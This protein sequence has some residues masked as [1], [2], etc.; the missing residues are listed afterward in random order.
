MY[1]KKKQSLFVCGKEP[2]A[3]TKLF[4]KGSAS[5]IF[6]VVWPSEN[7]NSFEE[8]NEKSSNYVAKKESREAAVYGFCH[9]YKHDFQYCVFWHILIRNWTLLCSLL[10]L[11]TYVAG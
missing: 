9:K 8:R 5:D 10:L 4:R 11:Q 1:T 6:Q 3:K 2:K 7:H